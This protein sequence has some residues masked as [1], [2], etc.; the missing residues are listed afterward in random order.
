MNENSPY[1]SKEQFMLEALQSSSFS[2]EVSNA[3][4]EMILDDDWEGLL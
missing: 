1:L 2:S 3:M 4:A